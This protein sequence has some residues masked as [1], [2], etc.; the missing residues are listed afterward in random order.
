MQGKEYK[1]CTNHI[2]QGELNKHLFVFGNELQLY[3]GI[4]KKK[5]KSVLEQKRFTCSFVIVVPLFQVVRAPVRHLQC[6][7]KITLLVNQGS[8]C[9]LLV[10]MYMTSGRPNCWQRNGIQFKHE[11]LYKR[12]R[13]AGKHCCRR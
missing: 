3:C 7:R 9:K 11:A 10:Y 8:M 13:S 12:I 6:Y 1:V 5:K 4:L 2:K